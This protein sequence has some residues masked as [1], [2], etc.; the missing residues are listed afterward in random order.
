LLAE[1]A[2]MGVET[3]APVVSVERMDPRAVVRLDEERASIV[4][5]EE[6]ELPGIP[7]F[8][9]SC[10]SCLAVDASDWFM[11]PDRDLGTGWV[12]P[13]CGQEDTYRWSETSLTKLRG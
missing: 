6:G 9:R 12:C 10:E 5:V 8:V 2:T 3:R 4:A 13:S 7:V 11:A 1:E